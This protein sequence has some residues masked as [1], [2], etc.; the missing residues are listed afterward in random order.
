MYLVNN[1]RKIKLTE[2]KTSCMGPQNINAKQNENKMVK[3]LL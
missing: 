1:G 2:K 3:I